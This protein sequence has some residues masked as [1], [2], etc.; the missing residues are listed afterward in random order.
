MKGGYCKTFEMGCKF[1]LRSQ[2]CWKASVLPLSL[3]SSVKAPSLRPIMYRGANIFQLWA[4][5]G[6]SPSCCFPTHCPPSDSQHQTLFNHPY[7]CA[8]NFPKRMTKKLHKY[9]VIYQLLTKT[10]KKKKKCCSFLF[11]QI[12]GYPRKNVVLFFQEQRIIRE[13]KACRIP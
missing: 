11:S 1:H 8:P 5:P 4:D 7:E 10:V 2:L 9:F 13:E 12:F 3:D 6:Q